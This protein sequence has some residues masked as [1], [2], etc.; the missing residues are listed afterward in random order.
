MAMRAPRHPHPSPGHSAR[1]QAGSALIE[2]ALIAP[3]F[4]MLVFGIVV[5]GLYF[6]TSIAVTY[7]AAEAARAS[8][9]GLSDSERES[10]AN[11]AAQSI[12]AD[13]T[14]LLAVASAT[15]TSG[16]AP[17]N[18]GLFEVTVAYDFHS[19]GLAGLATV[20]PI[21]TTNPSASVTVSHG[22]Y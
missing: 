2:F 21:P 18:S 22:G 5:Y 19:F 8:E 20:L 16:P 12:I 13:Y 11:A 1:D 14:P 10:L 3:V 7:A 6:A 17:G 4:L 9:A 15:I